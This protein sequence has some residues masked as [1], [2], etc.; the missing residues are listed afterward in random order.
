MNNRSRKKD[1]VDH[2]KSN[3]KQE[4]EGMKLMDCGFIEGVDDATPF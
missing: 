3:D 2:A 4:R 1:I